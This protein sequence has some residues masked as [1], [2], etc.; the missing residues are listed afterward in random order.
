MKKP[1]LRLGIYLLFLTAVF[2]SGNATGKIF[3]N[4]TTDLNDNGINSFNMKRAYLS[5]GNSVSDNVSYKVTYDMGT[6]EGGSAH[7]AFLKVAMLKWRTNTGDIMVGMQGMNMFKTMES[8]WG[9]RF[10][11]KMPMDTYKFSAPADMGVGIAKSFGPLSTSAL[12]VNGGGYKKAESDKYKKISVHALYGESRLNKNDGFNIGASFSYEPYA[13]DSIN[14]NTTN[15][16]GLFAGYSGNGF[17]GGL[18]YDTMSKSDISSQ[19]ISAYGTYKLSEKL[20]FLSRVDQY[21]A[22]LNSDSDSKQTIIAGV[23]YVADKGMTIAP[24]FHISTPEEGDATNTIV[25]N[26][27]FKF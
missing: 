27:Q 5:Y 6:N 10:I 26:F 24:T 18:E 8:T 2:A 14:T 23:S 19:I 12:I 22:D 15:V 17:R 25:V 3:F 13:I 7:T 11:A 9:H 16:M 1:I 4:H 21:D 20:S